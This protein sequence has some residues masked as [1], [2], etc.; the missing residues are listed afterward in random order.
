[1]TTMKLIFKLLL[2]V[3]LSLPMCVYAQGDPPGDEP[4]P[5]PDDTTDVPFDGGVTLLLAAGLAYGVK[6]VKDQ[7]S[8]RL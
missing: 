7:K 2:L 6:K 5:F 1:M 4:P 3:L 8:S